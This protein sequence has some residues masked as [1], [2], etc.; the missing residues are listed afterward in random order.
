MSSVVFRLLPQSL[1]HHHSSPFIF[2]IHHIVQGHCWGDYPTGHESGYTLDNPTPQSDTETNKHACA[3]SHLTCMLL[4]FGRK[5]D[6]KHENSTQGL[7][8]IPTGNFLEMGMSTTMCRLESRGGSWTSW[9]NMI[10]NSCHISVLK[11]FIGP[12]NITHL[13]M[14]GF[15]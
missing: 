14:C 1:D 2:G 11:P 9:S 3:H 5:P 13:K 7:A 8:K 12:Y 15:Y 6:Y 10:W 4:D